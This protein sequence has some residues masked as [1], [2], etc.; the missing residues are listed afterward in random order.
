[1]LQVFDE[2]T[3]LDISR[4]YFNLLSQTGYVR[5]DSVLRFLMYTFLLDFVDYTHMFFTE[6]DYNQVD[7]ALRLLFAGGG[8]LMPYPVFCINSATLGRNEYMGKVKIRKTENDAVDEDGNDI[9][10]SD[11][12]T[13]DD[14]PRTV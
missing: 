2:K 9:S 10:Y 8:C 5:H 11:R 3:A 1:M 14:Q 7:K 12:Y 4:R 6:E 13:Q